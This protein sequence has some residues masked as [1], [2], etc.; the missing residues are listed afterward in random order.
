M[1]DSVVNQ[2]LTAATP[3]CPYTMHGAE[4]P[5]PGAD[6]R[7]PDALAEVRARL[8]LAR[9]WAA[10]WKGVARRLKVRMTRRAVDSANVLIMA[11][12]ARGD[13]IREWRRA[14]GW[15]NAAWVLRRRADALQQ[16]AARLQ[17]ALDSCMAQNARIQAEG[18]AL[19]DRIHVQATQLQAWR[20]VCIV[21]GIPGDPEALRAALRHLVA[22]ACVGECEGR[23]GK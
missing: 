11:A 10:R 20:E 7:G 21:Y 23:C 19:A 9:R 2:Q 16:G 1:S 14:Q 3:D 8:D 22:S 5:A 6:L 4:V 12:E 13:E 18:N 15:S 17:A